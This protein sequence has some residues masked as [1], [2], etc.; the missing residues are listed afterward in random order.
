M[1]VKTAMPLELGLNLGVLV[2]G[3]IIDDE[4]QV[5]PVGVSFSMRSR[6]CRH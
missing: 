4:M 1:D 5:H 6:T 3:V 2:S